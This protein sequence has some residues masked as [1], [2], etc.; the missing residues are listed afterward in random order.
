MKQIFKVRFYIF[1]L[2]RNSKNYAFFAIDTT[3]WLI[4]T[5]CPSGCLYGLNDFY[6]FTGLWPLA[7]VTR[8][9]SHAE[10]KLLSFLCTR[11]TCQ[12]GFL[13]LKQQYVGRHVAPLGHIEPPVFNLTPWCSMLIGEGTNTNIIVFG[14]TRPRLESTIYRT[15]KRPRYSL[16]HRCG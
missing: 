7:R 12:I 11:T 6:P 8:Q 3:N 1:E 9:A 5:Q 10:Q 15:R 4:A 13:T 2:I 16:H 14:L